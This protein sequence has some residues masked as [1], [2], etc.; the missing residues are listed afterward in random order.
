MP[1][2][3]KGAC[4]KQNVPEGEGHLN[5]LSSSFGDQL[6][7]TDYQYQG[8]SD[9]LIAQTP[10]PERD[11]EFHAAALALSPVGK[12]EE[13]RLFAAQITEPTRRT[14][15]MTELRKAPPDPF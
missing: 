5:A 14:Q 12:M 2:R 1:F 10:G 4:L 8:I 11:L 13:A 15:A 9:T 3:E 7:N 6:S